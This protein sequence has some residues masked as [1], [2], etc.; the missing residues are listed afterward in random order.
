MATM[1]Q[2]SRNIRKLGSRIEN[3]SVRLTKKVAKRTLVSLIEGTPVDKGVARSNWRVSLG[4]P[5]RAVIPANNP[6]KRLGISE[7]ANATSTRIAGFAVIN[8]LKVGLKRGLGQAGQALFI[9]N[10]IPYLDKLRRGHSAQQPN[11]WVKDAFL[12]AQ[13]E[14][15]SARLL[16]P[17][18][19][20]GE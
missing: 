8:R 14:I 15:A 19:D 12:E 4:S 5:T 11:D 6:G 17:T 20:E 3:N 1:L 10:S 16:S 18:F 2:F 9:T 13:S 7:R